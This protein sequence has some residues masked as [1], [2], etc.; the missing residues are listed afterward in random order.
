[1]V[2]LREIF[3]D[4]YE[5]IQKYNDNFGYMPVLQWLNDTGV[6]RCVCLAWS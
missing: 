6:V 4:I 5:V 3:I 2:Y 1:M